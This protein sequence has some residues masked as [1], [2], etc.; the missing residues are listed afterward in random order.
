MARTV[1]QVFDRVATILQDKQFARYTVD[2]LSTLV[3]DGIEQAR[4]L[5]PDLFIGQYSV[6]LPDAVAPTDT[7]P[8]PDHIFAGLCYYVA[9]NAELRDDEFAVDGRAMVLKEAYTKKLVQ[10]T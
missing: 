2:E 1:Q 4:T 3:V 6:P 5:R 9:G 8:L 10:G 7:I